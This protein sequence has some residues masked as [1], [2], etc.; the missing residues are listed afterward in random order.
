MPPLNVSSGRRIRR[1][2][3]SVAYGRCWDAGRR[4]D[5]G[6][7]DCRC[8]PADCTLT[9]ALLPQ[10]A[11]A[12]RHELERLLKLLRAS[13]VSCC[14]SLLLACAGTCAAPAGKQP[15][16]EQGLCQLLLHHRGQ[17]QGGLARQASHAAVTLPH[18]PRAVQDMVQPRA[19]EQPAP[20]Q[21]GSLTPP[22][23][24]LA[25]PLTSE[26]AASGTPHIP[27]PAQH[28]AW[29]AA[30]ACCSGGGP[31]HSQQPGSQPFPA[32]PGPWWPP[33]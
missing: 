29:P 27:R 8:A 19:Q 1:T 6:P 31:G 32:R 7:A 11:L 17:A 4:S 10:V 25:A 5:P 22:W 14:A 23:S 26:P 24:F 20:V 12:E 2:A 9:A 16:P 3:S 21:A 28:A 13:P 15:V 18:N 33:A 30:A